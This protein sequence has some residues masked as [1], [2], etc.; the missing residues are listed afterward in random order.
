ML[1]TVSSRHMNVSEPLK[2]YAEQKAGKLLKYYDRIQEIE[3]IF[4]AGKDTTRVEVIV[5]AEH[6]NMF[7]A[8]HD[9]GDAYACVDQCVH[10]LERQLSDHKK[11]YRNR[12]H[13]EETRGDRGAGAVG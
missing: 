8:N 2:Q 9:V 4:D 6:K 13:P 1:V 12:K 5:N 11:M 7:I 10:K 3:V